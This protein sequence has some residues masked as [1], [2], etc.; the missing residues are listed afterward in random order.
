MCLY[1]LAHSKQ[2]D[3]AILELQAALPQHPLGVELKQ[4]GQVRVLRRLLGKNEKRSDDVDDAVVGENAGD[5]ARPE[6]GGKVR[7]EEQARK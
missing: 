5:E 7:H 1:H 6:A 4:F 3:V 2:G